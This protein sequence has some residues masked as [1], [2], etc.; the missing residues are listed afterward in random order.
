MQSCCVRCV[1]MLEEIGGPA[2]AAGGFDDGFVGSWELCEVRLD[3]ERRVR[4][5]LLIDDGAAVVICCDEG[6]ALVLVDAGIEH[7]VPFKHLRHGV[8]AI[9]QAI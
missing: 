9:L 4:D 1:Q 3:A 7:G 6:I 5:A 8:A 2:P